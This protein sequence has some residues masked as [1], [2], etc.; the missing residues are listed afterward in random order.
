MGEVLAVTIAKQ[1]GPGEREEALGAGRR[2]LRRAGVEADQIVRMDVPPSRGG[3]ASAPDGPDQQGAFRSELSGIVPLLQSS[4]LFGQKQGLLLV[5]ANFLLAAESRALAD[6]LSA[7]DPEAVAAALVAQPSLPAPL[8]KKIRQIGKVESV[9]P[10]WENQV[11]GWLVGQI[12]TKGLRLGYKARAALVQRFGVDRAA[13][14]RALE[15]LQGENRPISAEMIMERFRNRPDQPVF[16]ILDEIVAGDAGSALRRLGDYLANARS[17]DGRPFIL[18][19]TLESDLRLRL[20]ASHARDR[21]DFR[22]LEEAN[23]FSRILETAPG[24][25]DQKSESKLRTTARS[26]I[27]S[28]QRRH[29]RIWS[30]RK[31]F[32]SVSRSQQ[33]RAAQKALSLLVQADRTLKLYPAPLHQAVLE[34]T[35]AELCRVYQGFTAAR[36]RSRRTG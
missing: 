5:D 29:D 23:A 10:L 35:V 7:I 1:G 20:L 4:S 33:I 8:A 17:S 22:R 6:L 9:R 19:G 15:Q 21:E 26:R 25:L 11:H 3:G 28:S 27:R 12:K 30:Q 18:L 34:R 2:H 32:N 36:P 14:G 31:P 16:R 24:P 13:L